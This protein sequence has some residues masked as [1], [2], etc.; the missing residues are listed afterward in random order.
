MWKP[1]S[2]HKK[3]A[4]SNYTWVVIFRWRGETLILPLLAF[5]LIFVILLNYF[6]VSRLV[7]LEQLS[8]VTFII[9][10]IT[11]LKCFLASLVRELH[12]R[13]GGHSLEAGYYLCANACGNMREL[14][15][16]EY[17]SPSFFPLPIHLGFAVTHC[18]LCSHFTPVPTSHLFLSL[19]IRHC[20]CFSLLLAA[21]LKI[22]FLFSALTPL[23]VL[24]S[25]TSTAS[26]H[27][28]KSFIIVQNGTQV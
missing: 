16:A 14:L 6:I 26:S 13:C 24:D 23:P 22:P 5:S 20:P 3:M 18:S 10:S 21:F 9:A 25:H 28:P 17:L 12:E 7:S 2:F 8:F 11:A 19:A 27:L 4:G 1:L 15:A